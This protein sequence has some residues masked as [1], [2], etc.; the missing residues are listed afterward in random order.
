MKQTTTSNSAPS[1]EALTAAVA[2]ALAIAPALVHAL[3]GLSPDQLKELVRLSR[4]RANIE[5]RVRELKFSLGVADV[6]SPPVETRRVR[7]PRGSVKGVIL[8][9]LAEAGEPGMRISE[10]VQSSRLPRKSVERW[11]FSESAKRTAGFVK[12]GP[13]HYRYLPLRTEALKP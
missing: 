8:N 4:D 9:A 1:V 10:L 6:A 13:A 2:V 5:R 11:V 3:G 12:I 7:S